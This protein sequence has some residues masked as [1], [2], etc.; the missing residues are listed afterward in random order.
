MYK[1]VGTGRDRSLRVTW[2]LEEL[3]QPYELVFAKP[4]SDEAKA[5]NPTGKVPALI[6]QG[7]T[8]TDSVAIMTYLAD[9]HGALTFQAGTHDRMVQDGH[10]NF[11]L[12]EMDSVLWTAAKHKFVNPE[13]QRVPEV[14][15][16]L[17][18]EFDRAMQRL[19]D[20]L[21]GPFLMGETMT[22]A[23]ILAVHCLNWGFAAKFNTPSQ[24]LRDYSKR[25]RDRPAYKRALPP[26]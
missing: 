14:K 17:V 16:P 10:T 15:P 13:D 6:D 7:S 5:F 3:G 2:T 23:D 18:W 24:A 26:A 19:E 20:R 22:I 8:F 21:Q 11:V 12:E 4:G 1:V 9:H 25:M